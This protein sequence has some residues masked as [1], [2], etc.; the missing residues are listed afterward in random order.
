MHERGHF[1]VKKV[2]ELLKPDCYI[3]SMEEKI[4]LCISNCVPCIV[5]EK[6]RGKQEGKLQP[7]EKGDV[8]LDTIHMD[9]LGPLPSTRW[10]YNYVLTMIDAFTKFVWIFAVKSTTSD[11]T[12]YG[13]K[14][15]G[16]TFWPVPNC[17]FSMATRSP[18]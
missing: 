14:N 16:L 3:P 13:P 11:D 10:Q 9:H 2:M 5:A 1:G 4:R 7:L 6:K 8:P 12:S 17:V 15:F 18:T